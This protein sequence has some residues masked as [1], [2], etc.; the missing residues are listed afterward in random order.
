MKRVSNCQPCTQQREAKTDTSTDQVSAEAATA[1]RM[2][3]SRAGAGDEQ[4]HE[5]SDPIAANASSTETIH[6]TGKNLTIETRSNPRNP[7]PR[8]DLTLTSSSTLL[9]HRH[10]PPTLTTPP[11]QQPPPPPLQPNHQFHTL[12][13][14]ISTHPPST[15]NP[16]TSPATSS[17]SKP[18]KP[19][20]SARP[21]PASPNRPPRR[22][23]PPLTN[24]T[25]ATRARG[26]RR[27]REPLRAGEGVPRDAP[28]TQATGILTA[29]QSQFRRRVGRKGRN[30]SPSP[31]TDT[32][33]E[34]GQWQFWDKSSAGIFFFE[35][36]VG[37][38]GTPAL[39]RLGSG[40][41]RGISGGSSRRLRDSKWWAGRRWN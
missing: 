4:K 36:G 37:S 7:M 35:F 26:D 38:G 39:H 33:R 13:P 8:D 20:D 2:G 22:S 16:P 31:V 6:A 23:A 10:P 30:T 15:P 34:N 27:R 1:G 17:P 11:P 24:A 5:A 28:Q 41:L 29:R 12:N 40:G 19:A 9:T 14:P 32:I 25:T 18:K 21:R 3:N